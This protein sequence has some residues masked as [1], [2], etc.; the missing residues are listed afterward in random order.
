[1]KLFAFSPDRCNC[2]P[3]VAFS[4]AEDRRNLECGT[5]RIV[6]THPRALPRLPH[7]F[8]PG[9]NGGPETCWC[10]WPSIAELFIRTGT[11]RISSWTGELLLRNAGYIGADFLSSLNFSL[12]VRR[13]TILCTRTLIGC[14]VGPRIIT[15]MRSRVRSWPLPSPAMPQGRF[16]RSCRLRTVAQPVRLRSLTWQPRS[17]TSRRSH[18]HLIS[19]IS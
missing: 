17:E 16:W 13:R 7:I 18:A 9:P 15:N 6:F 19:I 5:R 12:A 4:Q 3:N 11:R 2:S 10:K 1:M 14:L 8:A